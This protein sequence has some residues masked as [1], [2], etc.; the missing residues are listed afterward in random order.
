MISSSRMAD[1]FKTLFQVPGA[2]LVV[3]LLSFA[4]PEAHAALLAYEGFDYAADSDL[5]GQ[6]GGTGWAG[7]WGNGTGDS[8]VLGSLAYTDSQGNVLT[9]AGNSA[10]CSALIPAAN[11]SIRRTNSFVRNDA[12]GTTW[13]SLLAQYGGNDPT[14]AAGF[15]LQTNNTERISL[16]K[17]TTN[18]PPPATW[19]MLY[20]GSAS[21]SA[22]TTNPI[23]QT[24][25]LV[26]RIDHKAGANDDVYLF[27]N[28]VLSSAPAA[29]QASTNFIDKAEFS[30]NAVRIFAGYSS[31]NYAEIHVDE[32]RVGET[33]ADVAPY[34]G[35]N[36]V[37]KISTTLLQGGS[38]VLNG[39]GGTNG[40]PFTVLT[41]PDV[42]S[43]VV[44]WSTN[45][46]GSFNGSGQFFYT[47]TAAPGPENYYRIRQP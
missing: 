46:A 42:S 18:V 31:G 1:R 2:L 7:P 28:P 26:L 30:F 3:I 14:R 4:R 34:T 47:N 12:S 5:S 33:Y 13:V 32:F 40:G 6:N 41:S 24:A 21:T 19:S 10:L 36:A 23:T 9:T 27:V 17:G 44:Q 38:I 16:G 15:Q 11:F 43:S 35:G 45:G 20:G 37:L 8:N 22:F 25:F 39:S 29:G